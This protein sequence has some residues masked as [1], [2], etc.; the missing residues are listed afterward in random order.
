M[1]EFARLFGAIYSTNILIERTWKDPPKAHLKTENFAGPFTANK[2]FES[3][4]ILNEWKFHRL[5]QL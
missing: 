2:L 4:Q 3:I 5:I 1:L